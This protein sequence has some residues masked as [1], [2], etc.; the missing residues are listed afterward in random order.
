MRD[1]G[2][3]IDTGPGRAVPYSIAEVPRRLGGSNG[4]PVVFGMSPVPP[5]TGITEHLPQASRFPALQGPGVRPVALAEAEAE[6]P[7]LTSSSL[8]LLQI[9]NR[10]D[11]GLQLI[12][13]QGLGQGGVLRVRLH[14]LNKVGIRHLLGLVGNQAGN[15]GCRLAGSVRTMAHGAF[16]FVQSGAIFGP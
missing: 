9:A 14:G 7:I 10:S 16:R 4:S 11:N 13:G 12:V 15:L 6:Q 1:P 2:P 8:L 3:A 5:D